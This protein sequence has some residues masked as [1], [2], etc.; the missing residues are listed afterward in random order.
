MDLDLELI[1][2]ATSGII[3][4]CKSSRINDPTLIRELHKLRNTIDLMQNKNPIRVNP[5][6]SVV[7]LL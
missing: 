4:Y 6:P 2:S 1:R 7:N 5:C 3:S